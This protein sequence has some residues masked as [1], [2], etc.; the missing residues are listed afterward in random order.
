MDRKFE[1]LTWKGWVKTREAINITIYKKRA[2]NND[3]TIKQSKKMQSSAIATSFIVYNDGRGI[4]PGK[5][6]G[7]LKS[8]EC[9]AFLSTLFRNG[10]QKEILK[11]IRASRV[12][13]LSRKIQAHVEN[14]QK[15][16]YE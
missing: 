9:S 1:F 7:K 6:F 3:N 2:K 13:G 12:A 4:G 11:S 5:G 15:N 8:S 14:L 16:T 10:K